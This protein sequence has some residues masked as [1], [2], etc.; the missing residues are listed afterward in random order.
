MSL[1]KA[2]ANYCRKSNYNAMMRKDAKRKA[3]RATASQASTQRNIPDNE[4]RCCRNCYWLIQ[5]GIAS[6]CCG[7]DNDV[8][9]APHIDS[10]WDTVCNEF[11][12]R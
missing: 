12:K 10:P 1:F 3:K 4:I 2:F 11:L 6:G 5:D 7:R 8:T 9:I